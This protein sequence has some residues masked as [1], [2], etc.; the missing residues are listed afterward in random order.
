MLLRYVYYS[1]LLTQ[2]VHFSF[3]VLMKKF[4]SYG[5][6]ADLSATGQIEC[7]GSLHE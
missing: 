2:L 1:P 7:D 3:W 5:L 4:V 6:S